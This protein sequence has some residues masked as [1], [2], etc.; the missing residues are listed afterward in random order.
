M[1]FKEAIAK[2]KFVVTAEIAPPKGT[3]ITEVMDIGRTLADW[4][5]AINVTDQQSSTMRLGSMA[6][7]HLLQ[8]IGVDPIYQ[9]TCRDRNRIALQS[10]LL[11]ANV[12]GLGMYWHSRRSTGIR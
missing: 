11:S 1:K 4:V 6:V 8:D 7:C 3:D 5:D 12:L 9:L 10:D 2:G